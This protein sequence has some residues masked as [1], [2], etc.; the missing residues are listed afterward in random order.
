MS[1]IER[2]ERIL[3]E[4]S[5]PFKSRLSDT[6]SVKVSREMPIKTKSHPLTAPKIS[7]NEVIGK[8]M[9]IKTQMFTR[10]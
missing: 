10:T 8:M 5:D 2:F 6:S 7:R 3:S 9:T 4:W 1:K